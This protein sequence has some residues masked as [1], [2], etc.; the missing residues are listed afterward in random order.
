VGKSK[1]FTA[2]YR[3]Y[4]GIHMGLNRGA[5]DELCEIQV[6]GRTAWK[7]SV[8]SDATIVI[9][10]PKLFGGDD[11][12]GGISGVAL[13]MMGGPTQTAP[14]RLA[15]MLGGGLVP[16]FRGVTSI[17]Y[18]GQISAMNPYPKPWAFR[19]RRNLAGWDGDVWYPQKAVINLAGGQI[20]AANPAH[21][22]YQLWTN[23]S[24]GR[25]LPRY[26]INDAVMRAAA[27]QLYDEAFG[28]CLRWTRQESISAFAQIVLDHINAVRYEDPNDGTIGIRLI[29]NDYDVETIPHFTY[30]TGLL[31]VDDDDNSSQTSAVNE[32][33]VEFR[34]PIDNER[35]KVRVQNN[36]S[37]RML[38]KL[39]QT[40]SYPGIPTP[41]LAL[42]VAERD[43]LA[44]SGF[45]KR[46]RVRLDRRGQQ[47]GPG[48]CFKITD[49]KRGLSSIVLR[50]LRI[51]EG[52]WGSGG[53]TIGAVQDVYAL[54][55]TTYVTH[56]PSQWVPP[57]HTPLPVTTR[58][59]IELPWWW[60]YRTVDQANFELIS[61]ATVYIG[62]LGRQP[63][64]LTRNFNI[65]TRIGSSGAFV[66][67][68]VGG[69]TPS[70][71]LATS[72][73]IGTAPIAATIENFDDLSQ[74]DVGTAALIDDE[75]VRVDSLDR[76]TGAVTFARGCLDTVPAAHSA[77]ARVWFF[78]QFIA[79]DPTEY[80]LGQEIQVQ[81]LS[82]TST[83]QLSPSSAGTSTI[84]VYEETRFA[85]PYPPGRLR[86]NG[87]V[88]PTTITGELVISWAHRDRIAQADQLV[89]ANQ[90][91]IG[92]E[93]GV[94]YS[95]DIYDGANPSTPVRQVT[96][97]AGTSYTYT[98]ADE[99]ADGGPF[100]SIRFVLWAQNA[101][102]WSSARIDWT[103]TR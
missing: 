22:L 41:E 35:K 89:D 99:L 81:L 91:S 25:G 43:L 50:A 51:D 13:L 90:T 68:G 71:V 98:E 56:Q 32:V 19:R 42:R 14:T 59:L 82:N 16:G 102:G 67:R 10:Q 52:E 44:S 65:T 70:G 97:L 54:P 4:F 11:A 49:P 95:L 83:S 96:G 27:D 64:G 30:G 85:K 39:S 5:I 46:F 17:Y 78:D 45:V 73:P 3:Y 26:M 69:F 87:Q 21:I 80:V 75:I 31:G 36:A 66:D 33:I 61:N 55:S 92:P 77:G 76:A 9:S 72:M 88:Y 48:Q 101:G 18:D 60:L 62:V 29:R 12:E 1:W 37:I 100:S 7:G 84:A 38:G 63:T 23:R 24:W 86:V 2:G 94:T 53:F 47:V 6:G 40:R 15:S 57:D 8:T 20:K 103:V 74:V 79:Q 34:S 93:S 28:L 58:R